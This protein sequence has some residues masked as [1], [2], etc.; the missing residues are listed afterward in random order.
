MGEFVASELLIIAGIG[1]M[2]GVLGGMLGVGGSLIMIPAL[3][4]LYG[5]GAGSGDSGVFGPRD[6]FDQHLYQAAAMAVNVAVAV[7]ATWRHYQARAIQPGVL[8]WMMPA[9]IGLILVGVAVSN[10]PIFADGRGPTWLGRVLAVFL[11]YVIAVNIRRLIKARSAPTQPANDPAP[12]PAAPTPGGSGLVGAMMGFAA[13][14]MGIG[15]GAIA[16]PMQQV[17]LRQRLRNCIAN[18]AA[19]MCVSAG[20]GAAYKMMSLPGSALGPALTV[21]ALLAPT[22]IVGGWIGGKLTHTVP[23]R[24]VRLVWIVLLTAAAWKMAAL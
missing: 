1:L 22:A 19:V 10:L 20:I 3:V 2:A 15:G 24:G 4:Y 6:E 14:L 9:A 12:E 5:Q 21:A 16:V 13:G 17:I 23:I 7:P 18:S 8:R 11:V